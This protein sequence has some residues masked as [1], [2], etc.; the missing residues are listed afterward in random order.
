[1]INKKKIDLAKSREIV[2]RFNEVPDRVLTIR[3]FVLTHFEEIQRSDKPLKGLHQFLL[4]NGI[5]VGTYKAF[6]REYNRISRARKTQV[7]AN[8]VSVKTIPEVAP[9]ARAS[10][11]AKVT[12][13]KTDKSQ[14]TEAEKAKKRGLGLRPIYLPDGTEVE[15]DKETGAKF[16]EI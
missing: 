12:P 5:D 9:P 3:Q 14:G 10:E 7:P 15:I 13:A 1:M 11:P 4:T 8:A 2:A 6:Q 16:F